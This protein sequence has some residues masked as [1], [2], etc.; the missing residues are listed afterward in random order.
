MRSI[1]EHKRKG[2]EWPISRS[3]HLAYICFLGEEIIEPA[4]DLMASAAERISLEA[5]TTAFYD[6]YH[7]LWLTDQVHTP[8]VLS[9]KAVEIFERD[10]LPNPTEKQEKL[11]RENRNLALFS[12]ERFEAIKQLGKEEE[13]EIYISSFHIA[14]ILA[15][16]QSRASQ[17]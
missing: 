8:R 16:L 15:S 14:Y 9:R 11:Y 2:L 7:L 1:E 6:V 13:S 3:K 17:D 4:E 10:Y 12:V 5:V